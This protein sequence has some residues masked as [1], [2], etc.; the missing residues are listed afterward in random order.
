MSYPG[1]LFPLQFK[2]KD[3][4]VCSEKVDIYDSYHIRCEDTSVCSEKDNYDSYHIRCE[5]I[6]VQARTQG[7][8]GGWVTVANE[9]PPP[10]EVSSF[11]FKISDTRTHCVRARFHYR[12][13]PCYI[14]HAR[15][16]QLSTCKHLH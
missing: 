7:G 12:S 5:D 10:P 2:C 15:F 9:T 6:S 16:I 13:R 8:G 4:S 1:Q 3:V 11:R 14:A